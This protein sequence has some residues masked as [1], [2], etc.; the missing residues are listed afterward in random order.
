MAH[1]NFGKKPDGTSY[2]VELGAN[3]V[4]SSTHCEATPHRN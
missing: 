1:T 3:W 2:V 4:R